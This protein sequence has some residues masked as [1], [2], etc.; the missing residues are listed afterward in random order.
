MKRLRDMTAGDW[1]DVEQRAY[2]RDEARYQ[3]EQER[4]EAVEDDLDYDPWDDAA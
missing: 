1:M 2:D 4:G 3:A